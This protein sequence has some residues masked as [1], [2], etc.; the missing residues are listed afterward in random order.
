DGV[1]I[2]DGALQ[3]RGEP[4]GDVLRAR[5]ELR[6]RRNVV[7]AAVVEFLREDFE[8]PLGAYEVD[9][10]RVLIEAAAA[11]DEV[12]FDF[13]RVPVQRLGDAAIF[14]Q[15][16]R[17]FESRFDANAELTGH[18]APRRYGR[19]ASRSRRARAAPR[20]SP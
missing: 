7:D 12:R 2:V 16:V 4:L 19:S 17:G 13:V 18:A 11:R 8:L 3:F 6:E 15:V 20:L 1:F 10:D 5:V 9:G 14:A